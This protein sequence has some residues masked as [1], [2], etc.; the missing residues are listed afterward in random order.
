MLTIRAQRLED[1]H[2]ACSNGLYTTH[3]G[4][5]VLPVPAKRATSWSAQVGG[6]AHGPLD[7]GGKVAGC[8]LAAIIARATVQGS[9]IPRELGR[10]RHERNQDRDRES[11]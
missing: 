11:R 1:V 4:G 3:V 6:V 2:V 7:I 9:Q 5:A 10:V 8:R